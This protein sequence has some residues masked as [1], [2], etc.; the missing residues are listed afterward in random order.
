MKDLLITLFIVIFSTTVYA[1]NGWGFLKGQPNTSYSIANNKGT[2]YKHN[3]PGN[4]S[5]TISWELNGKLYFYGGRASYSYSDDYNSMWMYDTSTTLWTLVS[6]EIDPISSAIYPNYGIKGVASLT[7]HPGTRT[8]SLT[9][10]HNGKLYLFGGRTDNM[11]YNDL[12]VYNPTTKLWT[13]LA[14]DNRGSATYFHAKARFGIKGVSDTANHPGYLSNAASWVD[15]GKLYL[16]GGGGYDSTQLGGLNDIWEY[17]LNTNMWT[18]IKGSGKINQGR[19]TGQ[20]GVASPSNTPASG[21][22][23]KSWY[24]KGKLYVFAPNS[25]DYMWEYDHSTNNWRYIKFTNRLPSNG[26]VYGIKGVEDSLNTPIV[27]YEA[28]SWVRNNKLCLLDY[29]NIWSY[30][31][32][33]NNWT[34]EGGDT[35]NHSYPDYGRLNHADSLTNPGSLGYSVLWKTNKYLYTLS[36]GALWCYNNNTKHWKWINGTH[37]S[38]VKKLSVV[39]YIAHHLNEPSFG[40]KNIWQNGDTVYMYGVQYDYFSNTTMELWRYTIDNNQWAL[41]NSYD[42]TEPVYGTKGVATVH[43]R[44]GIRDNNA[45]TWYVNNKLYLYGGVKNFTSSIAIA[46]DLWEYDLQTNMWRYLKGDS[47]VVKATYGT[48]GVAGII[49][50]PGIRLASSSWVHNGQ[51]YLFGGGSDGNFFYNYNDIWRYDISSNNWTWIKGDT[52]L[53]VAAKYG[54]RGVADS[55][56]NPGAIVFQQDCYLN[57]KLYVFGGR[58]QMFPSS[59]SFWRR[60]CNEL[61]EYDHLTNNW[62]WLTDDSLVK[63]Q[64]PNW[65]IKGVPDS[66]NSPSARIDGTFEAINGKL[67]LIGG[68][69]NNYRDPIWGTVEGISDDI[70]EYNPQTNLWTWID[71]TSTFH[72]AGIYKKQYIKDSLNTIGASTN[73]LSWSQGNRIYIFGANRLFAN[74]NMNLT[75]KNKFIYSSNDLWYYEICDSMQQC[76]PNAPVINIDSVITL[77]NNRRLILN[78]GNIGSDYLWSNGDTTLNSLIKDTGTYWVRVTNP[79]NK[80]TTDTFRVIAGSPPQYTISADTTICFGDTITISAFS[81]NAIYRWT[82]HNS[83]SSNTATSNITT[84]AGGTYEVM[85]TA[86]N[87]CY[88]YDSVVVKTKPYPYQPWL[89]NNG[90]IC[91]GEKFR[92][93]DTNFKINSATVAKLFD[94]HNNQLPHV[95]YGKNNSTIADSGM[96][97]IVRELN[98]CYSSDTTYLHVYQNYTPSVNITTTPNN[99]WPF[100]QMEFNANVNYAL[101]FTS[102]QWYKNNNPLFGE[103]NQKYQ[104]IAESEIKSGDIICVKIN[105]NNKC[106]SID[107]AKDCTQP[108]QIKLL[109]EP[110][111][112]SNKI[113]IYPNPANEVL[114]IEGITQE[115]TLIIYNSLGVNVIEKVLKQGS[116]IDVSNLPAGTYILE[117]ERRNKKYEKLKLTIIR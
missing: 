87:G 30:N 107:T 80:S 52:I 75:S 108:I 98:G 66:T 83:I 44:P 20:K 73:A 81:N 60:E 2:A 103:T 47:G 90:P 14:G 23:S 4:R 105:T 12:W 5:S 91:V 101:S 45:C 99:P 29:N 86:P 72:R 22:Y 94:K 37:N 34:W 113:K 89:N 97:Y 28:H 43:N 3:T 104:A 95:D 64:G 77:C 8:G 59:G 61:W 67:Y 36:N 11:R 63:E 53:H 85:I 33:T 70:W 21:D 58:T 116:S 96:Y 93:R 111:S 13:W 19:V 76:Y 110:I 46:N 117:I 57:G 26:N 74:M 51:L 100:V 62:T 55:N 15:N 69:A 24:Y 54:T 40:S 38:E 65:G 115:S 114:Y 50:N 102:F 9:W 49:N 39:P 32:V 92:I 17:N 109:V 82:T 35:L 25:L 7:N 56:N 79:A 88:V 48:L 106:A 68:Y 84:K 1:Q 78:A 18:W 31:L 27:S 6:G 41:I 10:T 42:N 112:N 16:A 71:G